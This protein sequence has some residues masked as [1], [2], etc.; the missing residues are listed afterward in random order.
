VCLLILGAGDAQWKYTTGLIDGIPL[1]P[2]SDYFRVMYGGFLAFL[3]SPVFGIGVGNYRALC[4]S[5]LQGL[6]GFRCDNHPHNYYIQMLA[7]TGVIGFLAGVMMIAAMVWTAFS[8][9]RRNVGHV[10][11]TTAFVVPFGLFFPIQSTADFFGQWNN[12][13]MWSAVALSMAAAHLDFGS[14]LAIIKPNTRL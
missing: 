4:D 5:L 1:G 12:I 13:F 8:N 10:V 2:D 6:D 9:G 14:G 3:D 11:A 7:E